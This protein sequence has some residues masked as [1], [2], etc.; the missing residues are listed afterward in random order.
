MPDRTRYGPVPQHPRYCTCVLCTD[1]DRKLRA[2]E[3][4]GVIP[5]EMAERQRRAVRS[6][7]PLPERITLRQSQRRAPSKG[8]GCANPPVLIGLG[9]V[10]LGRPLPEAAVVVDPP[11]HDGPGT[12]LTLECTGSMVPTITCGDNVY[13]YPPLAAPLA[14]GT[15]ISYEA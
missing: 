14:K 8:D 13:G 4:L 6:S 3:A 9:L 2:Q 7:T 1:P 12:R 5:G 15:I 11:A 10:L